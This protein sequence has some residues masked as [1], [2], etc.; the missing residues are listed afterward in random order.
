MIT[1]EINQN[2]AGWVDRT[3]S[4]EWHS[5]KI[6]QALTKE[7]DTAN[8]LIQKYGSLTFTP[9]AEDEIRI[10]Q[11]GVKIFAGYVV[12]VKEMLSLDGV[13][14]YD[15]E[16]RDYTHLLDRKLV[17]KTYQAQTILQI[18]T[19]IVANFAGPGL[20]VTNVDGPETVESI[21]FNNEDPS[22][23]IQRLADTYGRDWYVDYDKDLHFFTKETE[24]A[25]FELDDTGDKFNFSSLILTKDTTQIKN[26][27]FVEG[28]EELSSGTD[29]E[30]YIGDGTQ[31]TW[32]LG[33]KY[34]AFSPST[35][36]AVATLT[37]G[38]VSKTLGKDGVDTFS[39][40]FDA[41]Y[42]ESSRTLK[43]ATP[44]GAGVHIIFTAKYFFPIQTLLRNPASVVKYG[45]KQFKIVDDNIKSRAVAKERAKAEIYAYADQLVEG[46]FSTR[47][48]GL[49][50]GQRII[51]NSPARGIVDEAYIIQ[52]LDGVLYTPQK[53]EWSAT[54]VSV[55]TYDIID[56]LIAALEK[57]IADDPNKVVQ[58]A[59]LVLREIAVGRTITVA[60]ATDILRGIGV[61]RVNSRQMNFGVI[62]VA[63]YYYPSSF[64][65]VNRA[66][67][68]DRGCVLRV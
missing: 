47:E 59:E 17:N 46:E 1:I 12:R 60:N 64:A 67:F 39:G 10:K 31:A 52:K 2:G 19:D 6:V 15:C 30:E 8:F 7:V 56:F 33:E 25:P 5:L 14:S 63:G 55:K 22:K 51:I 18:I 40:G 24:V 9:G 38:G 50:A 4:V 44:P 13:L 68:A 32:V 62:W 3:A 36:A 57:N 16:A 41:L 66:C 58:T 53:M 43:F 28:A 21:V 65:D 11:D 61:A 29:F 37:V 23:A 49:R 48:A 42:N 20:T 35:G 34:Q 27:V 54:L 45:E 26:A